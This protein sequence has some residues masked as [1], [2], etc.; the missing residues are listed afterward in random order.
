MPECLY[1]FFFSFFFGWTHCEKQVDR[2]THRANCWATLHAS[3]IIINS[4]VA[5]GRWLP[6][7]LLNFHQ[8]RLID[9]SFNVLDVLA[10][11]S[12]ALVWI[13]ASCF[14]N[15]QWGLLPITHAVEVGMKTAEKI[16]RSQVIA[17]RSPHRHRKHYIHF[18]IKFVGHNFELPEKQKKH[19][20]CD[21]AMRYKWNLSSSSWLNASAHTGN[22]NQ[23]KTMLLSSPPCQNDGSMN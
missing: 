6:D 11:V 16:V 20:R 1:F 22:A 18:W 23:E 4:G 21:F 15:G 19:V 8:A 9:R 17:L 14:W 13:K 12:E 2:P 3:W 10:N 7:S 5:Q